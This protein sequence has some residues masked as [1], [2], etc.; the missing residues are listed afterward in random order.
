M[1]LE[2]PRIGIPEKRPGQRGPSCRNDQVLNEVKPVNVSEVARQ[3][4]FE[5]IDVRDCERGLLVYDQAFVEVWTVREEERRDAEGK[6]YKGLN[7]VKALLVIRKD[8]PPKKRYSLS[9]API[10]TDKRR[11]THWKATRY[12]V[13]RTIQDTKPEA[14]WDDLPSPKYRA[15]RPTLAIDALA[16]WFVAC[17]NL[18]MRARQAASDTVTEILGVRRLPDISYA[19]I[20]ELLLTIF[21]LKTLTKAQAIEL[22]TKHLVGRTKSTRSRLKGTKM[23]I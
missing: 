23:L 10:T 11:V 22:V 16:L 9:N 14:G 2:E 8:P 21:P 1:F 7:A 3:V 13:E 15:Y 12:F 19:T 18:N 5:P 20:R 4:S 6:P 17:V